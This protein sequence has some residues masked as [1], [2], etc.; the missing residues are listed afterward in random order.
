MST[1]LEDIRKAALRLANAGVEHF[2]ITA[3][4]GHLFGSRRG[5]DMKIDPPDSGQEVD[6]HRRCWV[7][8]GGQTPS[9]CVRL[10]AADLGYQGTDLDIVVPRGTGVF[11]AGGSLSF[12][13]GGLSLQELIIP[14]LSLEL[15]GKR[16]AM[17]RRGGELVALESVPKEITK[18]AQLP[19]LLPEH[20]PHRA[21]ARAS[22]GSICRGGQ[23]WEKGNNGRPSGLCGSRVGP[24]YQGSHPG[25][26]G[27]RQRTDLGRNSDR[28]RG[29]KG[30]AGP[31]GS[32]GHGQDPQG[33]PTD[34]GDGDTVRG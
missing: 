2:V 4:H 21:C 28:G 24:R 15:K 8:R 29:G 3:D 30:P 16:R 32:G 11:K 10:S 1:V 14:V 6:L 25:G 22:S 33:H 9:S 19:H 27:E 17:A 13:H 18:A 31:C 23:R 7:G 12:H 26:W 5:D 20:P 34:P